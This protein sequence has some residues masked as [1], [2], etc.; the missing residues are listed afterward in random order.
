MKQY[1]YINT[2]GQQTGPIGIEELEKLITPTTMIWCEG[3]ENWQQANTVINFSTIPPPNPPA[4]APGIPQKPF[5]AA[6][7]QAKPDNYQVWAILALLF[8]CL[9]LGIMALLESNKVNNEWDKG[10]YQT[11]IQASEKTRTYLY[12]SVAG[13]VF[14]CIICFILGV[15]GAL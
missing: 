10:N 11:A 3:M 1:Y 15:L 8:C 4:Y 9:P 13:G 14:M 6:Q 5:N 12:I 2:L 7:T